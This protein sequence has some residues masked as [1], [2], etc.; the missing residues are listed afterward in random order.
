MRHQNAHKLTKRFR[1]QPAKV[2]VLSEVLV[3]LNIPTASKFFEILVR[4]R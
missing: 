1:Q 4:L 3:L 2:G